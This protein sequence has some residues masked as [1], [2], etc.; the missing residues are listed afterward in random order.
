MQSVQTIWRFDSPKFQRW[1]Y[2]I[3]GFGYFIFFSII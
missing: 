1:Q 2:F 3:Y